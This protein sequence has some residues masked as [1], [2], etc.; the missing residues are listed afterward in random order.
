MTE[1]SHW[2]EPDVVTKLS[3]RTVAE[4][5]S[6]L[7][8][9][10]RAKG[11]KVFAVID[12]SVEARQVGLELRDTTLVMFGSPAAGTP[13]MAAS[14]LSALDLPLKV[15]RYPLSVGSQARLVAAGAWSA[16][17]LRHVLR[18]SLL[19]GSLPAGRAADSPP[20]RAEATGGGAGSPSPAPGSRT[21]GPPPSLAARRSPPAHR[22]EPGSA[23]PSLVL[24]AGQP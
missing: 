3:P 22:L 6:R 8:D 5:V 7:T 21:P 14:P 19:P 16:M 13:V 10:V 2:N 23:S 9:L 20:I 1:D 4:T 24:S 12:Q 17:L 11:M 15:S 18:P